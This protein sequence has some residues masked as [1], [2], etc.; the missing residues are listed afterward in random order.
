[1]ITAVT[2]DPTN[3]VLRKEIE[4]AAAES[5]SLADELEAMLLR[6]EGNSLDNLATSVEEAT[7]DSFTSDVKKS[8]KIKVNSE[9]NDKENLNNVENVLNELTSRI[10]SLQTDTLKLVKIQPL[11]INYWVRLIPLNQ[12]KAMTP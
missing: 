5:K 11:K 6:L 4:D 1:M 10:Q 12:L 9:S 3:K 7:P 8:N 2:A